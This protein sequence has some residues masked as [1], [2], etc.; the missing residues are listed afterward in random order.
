L[1]RFGA[2]TQVCPYTIRFLVCPAYSYLRSR[3]RYR[4]RY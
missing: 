3:A 1:R 4:S 2:D